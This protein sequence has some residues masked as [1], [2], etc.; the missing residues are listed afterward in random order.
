LPSK[1][2]AILLTPL[3]IRKELGDE[4]PDGDVTVVAEKI[5]A[6]EHPRWGLNWGSFLADLGD[7]AKLLD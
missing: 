3:K 4:V 1:D 6:M 2:W 5:K 7:I